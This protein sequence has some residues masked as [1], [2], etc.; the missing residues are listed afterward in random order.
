MCGFL[1]I[2]SLPRKYPSLAKR[3]KGRFYGESMYKK[4][5]FIPLFQRGNE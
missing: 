1:K 3:G 5:P 4:S 2:L